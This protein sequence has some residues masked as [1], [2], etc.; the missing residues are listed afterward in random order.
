LKIGRVKTEPWGKIIDTAV[1]LQGRPRKLKLW[2]NSNKG[3]QKCT[4]PALKIVGETGISGEMLA[5]MEKER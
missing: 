2:S 4:N 1:I 5:R 3:E